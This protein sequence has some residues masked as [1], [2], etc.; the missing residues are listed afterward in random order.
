V[1]FAAAGLLIAAGADL[2]AAEPRRGGSV[3]ISIESDLSTLDPLNSLAS[4]NDREAGIIV[5]DTLLDMDPK[6][7]IVPHLAEKLE[8]AP[9]ATWFKITL[10]SGVKFHDD[11]PLDAQAVIA[12]FKRLMDPA[13]RC[14]CLV[15]LSSV[16]SIEATG[17]LEVTFRMKA[18]AAHFPAVLT[19]TPGMIV[20][21][22]AVEK[23]GKD[24]MSNPVGTGPFRFK[25]W[26]R[27]A[28][29]VFVRNDNYW[30]K[31]PY[32]DQVVLRPMP[33]EQTRY[34]SL[35]AGNLD[36][37]MNAAPRDVV[38]ARTDKKIQVVNPG[39]L[40][41]N[42]V[43]INQDAPD[44]SDIRVRQAL[45]YAIDRDALNRVVNKGIYKVANTVFGTGLSPHEQVDGY[46]GYD[47]AKAKKL[48]AEYGK[49]IKLKLSVNAAPLSTL[50]GQALQQMWKKAG[51]ETEIHQLEQ[52]QL[53]R[54]STS[55]DF[56]IMLY[57][58]AGR[59]DPDM[60]V[61]QFFHSASQTNRVGYKN[62]ELDK[63]LDAARATTDP[64]ARLKLYRGVNNILAR[65]LPYLLLTYFD[66]YSLISSQVQGVVKVPD[67][68]IRL[69]TVWKDK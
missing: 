4:F 18:P 57:R 38:D 65:D 46:P 16:A 35:K 67:G 44:V 25:E 58:W 40:A 27:G 48:V 60:N 55:R 52:V 64:A 34:A 13:L 36:I 10:R 33:D 43:Q 42:F 21:P 66:N 24:Y 20:S 45:A 59:A 9:D 26:Q 49:P 54:A 19:D 12:H 32:L 31:P 17:P 56:Q 2:H 62:P 14:R 15:D 7:Q 29:I 1:T 50:T 3:S 63:L 5:Y 61:Y 28:Q 11:T 41:T 47:L 30:K 37:I 23:F 39:S 68:L 22:A 51:I 8:S 69:D 6:G 53:I